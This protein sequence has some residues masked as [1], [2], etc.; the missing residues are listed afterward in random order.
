SSGSGASSNMTNAVSGSTTPG[1]YLYL[2]QNAQAGGGN[3]IDSGT[4]GNAGDAVSTLTTGNPGGGGLSGDAEAYGGG[5]GG[6][7]NGFGT[8]TGVAPPGGNATA[9]LNL[10]GST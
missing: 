6:T 5:G 2:Q 4:P 1:H 7:F 3:T 9:S 10:T 8:F